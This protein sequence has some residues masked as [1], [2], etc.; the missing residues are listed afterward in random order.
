MRWIKDEEKIRQSK[1]GSKHSE[2]ARPAKYPDV[3]ERLYSEYR[4]LRKKGL[5][6][7]GWLADSYKGKTDL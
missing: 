2:H 3:E 6:M 7:K 4:D 1:K 5:K